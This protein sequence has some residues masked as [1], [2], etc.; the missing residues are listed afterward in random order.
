ML[1]KVLVGK[2][3]TTHEKVEGGYQ[4]WGS[5]DNTHRREAQALN[6]F[7]H[8]WPENGR[9]LPWRLTKAQL[10]QLDA[11]MKNIVWPRYVDRLYYDGCSFWVKPGRMWKTCRKVYVSVF[12]H[13]MDH[14][15]AYTVH[16]LR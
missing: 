8:V 6:V 10:K 14:V 16:H 7:S 3:L 4:A 2:G 9:P 12:D 1:V 11:R 13:T 5:K 15:I